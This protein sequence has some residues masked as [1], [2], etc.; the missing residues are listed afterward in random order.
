MASLIDWPTVKSC[1]RDGRF[2]FDFVVGHG[3]R[4]FPAVYS[5]ILLLVIT[6]GILLWRHGPMGDIAWGLVAGKALALAIMIGFTVYGTL[7][8][9]PKL[10]LSTHTEAYGI[11]GAYIR[12]AHVTFVCGVAAT[13]LGVL[14]AHF[15]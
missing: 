7:V 11:Y 10:Q 1:A 9:W 3:R 6:G 14:L 15:V 12:R 2:P 4:I 13:V 8:A 5:A